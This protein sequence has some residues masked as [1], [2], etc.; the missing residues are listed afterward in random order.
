MG[1]QRERE[2]R[3]AGNEES[4]ADQTACRVVVCGKE[5]GQA[6]LGLKTAARIPV[7]SPAATPHPPSRPS[8]PPAPPSPLLPPHP[9]S[10]STSRPRPRPSSSPFA[11]SPMPHPSRYQHQ[12]GHRR[13]LRGEGRRGGRG[14]GGAVAVTSG[15][16]LEVN[17]DG[18]VGSC[19]EGEGEGE[20]KEKGEGDGDGE[21]RGKWASG[22]GGGRAGIESPHIHPISP[23]VSRVAAATRCGDPEAAAVR[24]GAQ[25][26]VVLRLP[27]LPLPFDRV[28]L[29]LF[30]APSGHGGR[31]AAERGSGVQ[32]PA[33]AEATLLELRKS[34][35]ALQACTHILDNSGNAVA[36][37]QA[38]ATLQQVVLRD[39]PRIPTADHTSLHRYC[40][41]HIVK[42]AVAR[43]EAQGQAGGGVGGAGGGGGGDAFVEQK[44]VAVLAV[45]VK[46]AWMDVDHTYKTDL[47]SSLRDLASGSRGPA[48][49]RA[50][51]SLLDALVSEFNPASATPLALPSD[52]HNRCRIAFQRHFLMAVLMVCVDAVAAHMA[53]V[54]AQVEAT[55]GH[56]QG[57]GQAQGGVVWGASSQ[58]VVAA[59]LNVLI[60]ALSW[61]FTGGSVRMSRSK[62]N[63]DGSL[64][65]VRSSS[66]MHTVQPPAEWL[67]LLLSPEL[68]SLLASVYAALPHTCALGHD[69]R[70][71]P[72]AER[73]RQMAVLLCSL[74][75]P[76]LTAA[77]PSLVSMHVGRLLSLL[78]QWLSPL[79][80]TVAAVA[81][82]HIS[83]RE[84]LDVCRALAALIRLHPLLATTPAPS[85]HAN[86]NGSANGPS[87]PP[88]L[89]GLVG[90]LTCTVLAHGAASDDDTL[91]GPMPHALDMLL[92]TWLAFLLTLESRISCHVISQPASA[93]HQ[94]AAAAAA[95]AAE[96]SQLMHAVA[97][98]AAQAF[99]SFTQHHLQAAAASALEEEDAEDNMEAALQAQE[100][101]MA[102]AAS[103][104]RASLPASL[105][106]LNDLLSHQKDLLLKAADAAAGGGAGAAE[107]E[108]ERVMEQ[109]QWTVRMV[110]YVLA[111][112][113]TGETPELP[114]FLVYEL[115][116]HHAQ[117]LTALTTSLPMSILEVASLVL[118]PSAVATVLSPRLM[119]SLLW[120]FARWLLTYL[121]PQ[122]PDANSS[123]FDS[124]TDPPPLSPAPPSA[125]AY[126]FLASAAAGGALE[127]AFG[128]GEGQGGL[129]VLEGV[130]RAGVAALNVWP[131]EPDVQRSVCRTLLLAVTRH[132]YMAAFLRHLVGGGWRV[133]GGG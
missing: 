66:D 69:W 18:R 110:G 81:Q 17:G 68:L 83:D 130:L 71:G 97:P 124:E 45:L 103:L 131:G 72:L 125:S 85:A 11:L 12:M 50:A 54:K 55:Q 77:D 132:P 38:A 116:S 67:P 115:N 114:V 58:A 65:T 39:W 51:F 118:N 87:C 60:A 15:A 104:A 73:T 56:V 19:G 1:R 41:D 29:P 62:A 31:A 111:D 64:S 44:M 37:F 21:G 80:A 121:L 36:C 108:V 28:I 27:L 127:Q 133:V 48:V 128:A 88:T 42:R 4:G 96:W 74:H 92:D 22:K 14:R 126:S 99:R 107:G 6:K 86:A 40:L 16:R 75:G 94:Q 24:L 78:L 93:P 7:S 82:A 122:P 129:A 119:E 30:C 9:L 109:V 13:R 98:V 10:I 123:P 49:Q 112:E 5:W 20:G 117:S 101:R 70:E 61:D 89:L 120:F 91:D 113:G 47:F 63:D 102:A 100:Q 25:F 90:E 59:A 26:Q 8:A 2:Y 52:F 105:P 76:A 95:T 46:R 3:G 57:Q 79:P 23:C 34:P 53:A 33:A 32:R 84:L 43:E 106:L 35:H